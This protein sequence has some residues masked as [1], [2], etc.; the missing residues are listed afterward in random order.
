TVRLG[1]VDCHG[2]DPHA[3]TKEQAHVA[4]RFPS[5]WP[6]SANPVRSYA[7]LNHERPEF[8][9][10]VNPGDLRVAHLSCGTMG[11]HPKEVLQVHK[12]MMTHGCMLWGAVLYNNGGVP[13]KRAAFGEFY[14]M[15]GVPLAAQTV[16]P[17]TEEGTARGGS[18]PPSDPRP[19]SE[20]AKTAT[21]PPSSERG[22]RSRPDVALPTPREESGRPLLP[23]LS[24]RGLGTQSRVEPALVGL[25]KTRLLDPT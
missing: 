16:P 1:C 12:S 11:C 13:G 17:P 20:S 18:R 21:T 2:G 10:F 9:R 4:P 8:V 23:R 15:H 22:G 24:T 14:S 5:A 25:Q 6:S 19:R 7:L 3:T